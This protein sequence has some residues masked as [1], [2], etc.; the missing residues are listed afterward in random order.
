[1]ETATYDYLK[2]TLGKREALTLYYRLTG[3]IRE[4]D[5]TSFSSFMAFRDSTLNDHTLMEF[6]LHIMVTRHQAMLTQ[7]MPA[8]TEEAMAA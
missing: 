8:A 2:V 5:A 1:M 3:Y 7:L 4:H 6:V